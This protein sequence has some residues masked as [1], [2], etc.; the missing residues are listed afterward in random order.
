MQEKHA[1]IWLRN[2]LRLEDHEAFQAAI[3]KGYR[4]LPVFI[5]SP[6][7]DAEAA[8][9]AASHVWLHHALKD[10]Q[11]RLAEMGLPL[12]IR[13][14]R[15]E[16]VL[17]ALLKETQAEAIYWSRRYE[18]CILERDLPLKRKFKQAGL[19]V[20][21]FPGSLL[22]EPNRLMNLSGK[23]YKV[24]TAFW[25]ACLKLRFDRPVQVDW[26]RALPP[27]Q[28]PG[29][30]ALEQ[31]KLLPEIAWH[32]GIEEDWDISGRAG[33]QRMEAFAAGRMSDY[34]TGRNLPG[35]DGTSRLSP[36][37]HFG[38]LSPRQVYDCAMKT[39]E[40]GQGRDVFVAEIGWREFAYY[41]LYHFPDTVRE[42]LRSEFAAFPWREDPSGLAAWQRGLTG[43]PFVDAGMRQ[44]WHSGWMHNRVRMVVASFLVKDLMQHWRKGAKWFE[45]TLVDADLAANTLGWQ[46]TSGCG[47]DAAPYFRVFNPVSQG[48]KF[49]PG[50]GY[51]RRWVPELASLPDR[52]LHEPWTA[53]ASVLESAGLD[54]GKDYPMPIVDHA[55]CR[56]EALA[57]Y[58]ALRE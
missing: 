15:I 28:V 3:E 1:I 6:E 39:C 2:D 54:L 26:E 45:N 24:F 49:D 52:Y 25:R 47:A 37:L 55:Q 17:D 56:K 40:E 36:Y 22:V 18:P 14:G 13:K 27:K 12:I 46:W 7:E 11:E 44:L 8:M 9:G 30:L 34:E 48:K 53:P 23:P 58:K 31:L 10:L 41:L 35:E 38:M 19:D 4:I 43:Y 20:V 33:L 50:G 16:A 21:S 42:P 5:W 57:A 51:I 29:G 32:Q